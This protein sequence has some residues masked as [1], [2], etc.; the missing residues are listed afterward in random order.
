MLER[1]VDWY[2]NEAHVMEGTLE[3]QKKEFGNEEM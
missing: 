2:K 1:E 3:Q